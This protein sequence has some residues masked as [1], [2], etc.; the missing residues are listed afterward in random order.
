MLSHTDYGY[1]QQGETR[2]PWLV[3]GELSAQPSPVPTGPPGPP[4]Q[5]YWRYN[6][7]ESSADFA[8][9]HADTMH[10]P[11]NVHHAPQFTFHQQRPEQFWQQQPLRS[12]SYSQVEGMPNSNSYSGG[13]PTDPPH[14]LASMRNVPLSLEMQNGRMMME[15]PGPHSAPVE[16]RHH[17]FTN[18]PHQY[19]FPAHSNPSNVSRIGPQPG[20]SSDWYHVPPPFAPVDEE[21]SDSAAREP[22]KYM[23]PY[24]PG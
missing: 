1:Q 15:A 7:T 18:Q 5:H 20:Y 9:F 3:Q 4:S 2:S 24:Q 21:R 16:Q 8:P 10:P 14:Q 19:V 11:P 12:M 22:S 6:Q 13:F 17:A 23:R